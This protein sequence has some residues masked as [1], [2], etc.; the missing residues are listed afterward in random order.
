MKPLGAAPPFDS[1]NSRTVHS[2]HWKL[3]DLRSAFLLWQASRLFHSLGVDYTERH[4][5]DNGEHMNNMTRAL[6]MMDLMTPATPGQSS[7]QSCPLQGAVLKA[8]LEARTAVTQHGRKAAAAACTVLERAC[9][10]LLVAITP[11]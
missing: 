7:G 8:L 2:Q 4:A 1:S 11:S 5:K 6:E 10:D 9:G 3:T